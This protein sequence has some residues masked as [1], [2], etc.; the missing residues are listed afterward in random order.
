MAVI[1]RQ[2]K[3]YLFKTA[4]KK[5]ESSAGT[6]PPATSPQRQI[7]D[8][9]YKSDYES[10]TTVDEETWFKMLKKKNASK[11]ALTKKQPK[12]HISKTAASEKRE[13]SVS[14]KLLNT[15]PYKQIKEEDEDEDDVVSIKAPATPP[16]RQIKDEDYES[17][18]TVDEETWYNMLKR[19]NTSK[20]S[21]GG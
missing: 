3:L 19:K 20:K 9:D 21:A 17:D 12:L 18:T 14:I 5:N 15:L 16:Q 1:K 6:N 11:M 2:P 13:S 10:D 7:K 4:L 8:E